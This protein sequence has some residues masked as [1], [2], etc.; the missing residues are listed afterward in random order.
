MS[1]LN[2]KINPFEAPKNKNVELTAE[3]G[4]SNKLL[5]LCLRFGSLM[6]NS[7]SESARTEDSIE[8]IL[9]A[10]GVED[11]SAFC[12]PTLILVSYK[13]QEGDLYTSSKRTRDVDNNFIRLDE[14]N[15]LSRDLCTGE[16][17]TLSYFENEL[18]RIE[19]KDINKPQYLLLGIVLAAFGFNFIFG[20]DLQNSIGVLI[21]A[22]VMGAVYTFLAQ[23]H[24]NSVFNNFI[25]SFIGSVI[26]RSLE[27]T[28]LIND[29]STASISIIMGLVPGM[30]LTNAIRE[31]LTKDYT[32]GL[33][34]LVEST[35]I[36]ISLAM[37]SALA[38]LIFR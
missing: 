8:R 26:I 20:G 15:S 36:A 7:G 33:N 35:F 10:Y 23:L 28:S 22:G 4:S 2:S 11:A 32:S 24:T 37:G 27:Y 5:E 17:K 19:N 12:L 29:A 9:T 25:S 1:R 14:L 38:L 13:D 30:I 6:I 21:S 18:N 31:I 3:S 34:K 16:L